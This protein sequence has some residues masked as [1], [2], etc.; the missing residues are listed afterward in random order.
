MSFMKQVNDYIIPEYLKAIFLYKVFLAYRFKQIGFLF[1]C[2]FSGLFSY[3][4]WIFLKNFWIDYNR[5]TL[6]TDTRYSV[7]TLPKC[8]FQNA[9]CYLFLLVCH[10]F[11]VHLRVEHRMKKNAYQTFQIEKP[12]TFF[13]KDSICFGPNSFYK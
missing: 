4:D 12:Y 8:D 5:Q 9:K 6:I 1:I 13:I 11:Y 7:Q 2:K 3:T 10:I